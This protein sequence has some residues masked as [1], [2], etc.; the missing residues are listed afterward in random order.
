MG[1]GEELDTWVQ[2]KVGA[3]PH[4]VRTLAKIAKQYPQLEYTGLGVLLQIECQYL[5]RTVHGA[6]NI[7]GPIED[8]P[9]ETFF[10]ALF[11]G[12]EVSADLREILG[13]S[14]KCGGLGILDP[15]LSVELVC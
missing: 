11:L 13:R 5:Q 8:A 15:Y 10:P 2:P 1:P 7:M 9:R 3:W 6:R 4:G 12:E 14:V